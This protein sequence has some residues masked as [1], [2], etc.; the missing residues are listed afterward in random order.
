MAVLALGHVHLTRGGDG[1]IVAGSRGDLILNH[2]LQ[3]HLKLGIRRDYHD[4]VRPIPLPRH[5]LIVQGDGLRVKSVF[6]GDADG[7]GPVLIHDNDR[8]RIIHRRDGHLRDLED[9]MNRPLGGPFL[10]GVGGGDRR[11]GLAV[12]QQTHHFI[13]IRE[14]DRRDQLIHGDCAAATV[15]GV[16]GH[17]DLDRLL[18]KGHLDG[19]GYSDIL[20]CVGVHRAL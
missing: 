7:S 6:R 14:K 13:P 1:A 5:L 16:R 15:C 9:R 2:F 11:H 12:C 8:V 17:G 18:L 20:K 10:E 4:D 3:G 19:V